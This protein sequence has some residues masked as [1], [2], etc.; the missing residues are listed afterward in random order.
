M[1]HKA[2]L[3]GSE[4]DI[5]AEAKLGFV[6]LTVDKT[7]YLVVCRERKKKVIVRDISLLSPQRYEKD[8]EKRPDEGLYL[9]IN[10]VKGAE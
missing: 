6:Y 9:S 4:S 7:H 3:Q 10:E 8:G 5:R 1:V 2:V